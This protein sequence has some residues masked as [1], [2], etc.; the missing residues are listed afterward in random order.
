MFKLRLRFK[1]ALPTRFTVCLYLLT[2]IGLTVAPAMA[3]NDPI[4]VLVLPF[5]VNAQEDLSYLHNQI[6]EMLAQLLQKEGAEAVTV[7]ESEI[8][9]ALRTITGNLDDIRRLAQAHDAQ[10]VI[11]GSFTLIS[12]QFS[13]DAWLM[14]AAPGTDPVRFFTQGRNLENLLAVTGDLTDQIAL[15]LFQRE[16]IA[17]ISVQ[18]NQRIEAEA[19]LRVIGTQQG[20]VY[21]PD[22]LS[23]D[24]RAIYAMGFFDDVRVEAQSV[25]D[26]RA[27]VFHVKEKPTIRRINIRGNSYIKEEDIR[28]N[29]TISTGAI[30]N[31]FRI[32]SNI[33]QIETLYKNK[34]YH[35]VKVDYS[36]RTLDHN[37]AD[38]DFLITEGPKIYVTDITFEGNRAFKDKALKKVI[39]VSTKGF[40]Y[41]LTSSGDLDRAQL[42]QDVAR[43]NAFY[44]N[45]GYVNVRVGE[46]RVDI[47]PEGIRITFE[48]DEGEQFKVG[49]IELTGDLILP[50][51]ELL[52]QLRTPAETYFNRETVR[53]DVLTL[54]DIYADQ[55]YAYADISPRISQD[56]ERLV[57]DITFD[58][59]KREQILLEKIVIKGNTRTRDKVIR[60]ELHV[61][62]QDLFKGSALKRSIRNLHR[63]DYFEDIKVDTLRGTEEDKMVLMLDVTEKPTGSFSFG[64]GYSS[65]ETVFITGAIAQRNLF[66]R[67]QTIEFG[68]QVGARTSR[69]SLNFTEPY[70]FDTRLSTT[71]TA[72]NQERDW[73]TYQRNSYGGG[74]LLGYPVADYTRFYWGY[75]MDESTIVIQPGFED[76]VADT[77]KELEGTHLT[78][79]ANIR[80]VYDSRDNYFNPTEGSRHSI[81]IEY[82]GLGG[83]IGFNKYVGQTTWWVPLY[84]SLV[85]SANARIGLIHKNDDAKLLPDYDKFY[86]GGINS[87]RG[88]GW[89]GVFLTELNQEGNLVKV[90][91]E[92][93]IQFN[94]ELIFPVL[95]QAGVHGVVF[96]DTGNV[97]KGDIDLTDMRRSVGAGIRWLSPIAPIRV[98]YGYI[99]DRR[100]GE[101]AGQ[102]EFTLGGVF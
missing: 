14:A 97:Y 32:Y 33:D 68:G 11:W 78:S 57:V 38:L 96:F 98:E 80:L 24:L 53:N 10:H 84:K 75:S 45:Q 25:P 99:L 49:R 64:A 90:G 81:Y 23:N 69:F 82:A 52:Q 58:A 42:D 28:D 77:I 59:Q 47:Q 6:A 16:T 44:S 29:L 51:D 72:Y 73:D 30:L 70:L 17:A 35:Q 39:K 102:V 61:Q 67:G 88:F 5:Q 94:L 8:E 93:M 26:G 22:A 86:L 1:H 41:W 13:L 2:V 63:L 85:G 74:V 65:E 89:R 4:R 91:G 54:T 55:G 19:I 15:A 21:K 36:I 79:S 43:L 9:A 100:E 48:I 101:S 46:P 56:P 76:F 60:R 66:G 83:D 95:P 37:Q 50:G 31:I 18:G 12:R 7:Q 34:N 71:L 40:F 62:E 92:K 3:A 27:I 20:S 87:M